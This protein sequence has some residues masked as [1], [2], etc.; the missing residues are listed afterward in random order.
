V[1]QPLDHLCGSP[2]DPFQHLNILSVL[3]APGLD[4]VLQIWSNK[5]REEGTL[6]SLSLMATLLLM[7]PRIAVGL[8]GCK[9]ALL[10]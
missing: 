5:G 10:A 1:L 2:L 7:Q 8:L 4:T 6:T 9:H 3:E